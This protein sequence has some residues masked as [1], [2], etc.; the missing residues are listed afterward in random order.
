MSYVL[1][2]VEYLCPSLCVPYDSDAGQFLHEYT[3][4]KESVLECLKCKRISFCLSFDWLSVWRCC[5]NFCFSR[6]INGKIKTI[7]SHG[8]YWW[9]TEGMYQEHDN[10]THI[11]KYNIYAHSKRLIREKFMCVSAP[12]K[13]ENEMNISKYMSKSNLEMMRMYLPYVGVGYMV[14]VW[15]R[16]HIEK[17]MSG[18]DDGSEQRRR[19]CTTNS[20]TYTGIN[21]KNDTTMW[22]KWKNIWKFT[23]QRTQTMPR[24]DEHAFAMVAVEFR[25]K[26]KKEKQQRK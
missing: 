2:I 9:Q 26:K 20:F 4:M 15:I 3:K 6:A 24:V 19:V 25:T 11:A 17:H 12:R 1:H 14:W 16:I 22:V 18:G 21:N 23:V 8:K 13:Q 5:C 10:S 7:N